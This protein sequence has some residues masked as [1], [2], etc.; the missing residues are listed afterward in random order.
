M[1][2]I[3]PSTA[4]RR[5]FRDSMR[6]T[7]ILQ[8]VDEGNEQTVEQTFDHERITIGRGVGNT[9]VLKDPTR[10]VSTKHAEI[11][12]RQGVW[13][14]CDVGS[15]NG[16]MLNG[17]RI[18]PK[19]E[20]VLHDGDQIA[21][22]QYHLSFRCAT[23]PAISQAQASPVVPVL[24]STEG[25]ATDSE[26]LGYFLHRAYGEYD[27]TS[28][29]DLDRHLDDVLHR[30][31]G[32]Y[33]GSRAQTAL[34][35]LRAVLGRSAD[36]VVDRSKPLPAQNI[37]VEHPGRPSRGDHILSVDAARKVGE[38]L[39]LSGR[40]LNPEHLAAQ[41][42]SVLQVVCVGLADAVR[43]RRTFQKEFEV[44]ATRILARTPNPIKAA[45]NAE[46]IATILLDPLSKGLSDEQAMA[47]LTDVF[48]DLT[49]HQLGLM[50][51]FRECIRGLLKE[52]DPERLE[53]GAD[54]R[55]KEKRIGLLGGGAVRAEAAAWRRYKDKHRQLSEEEVKVF[56]R[57][58]APHFSKGY[59]SVHT[60]RPRA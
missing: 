44:E 46:E 17:V 24:P 48:Q 3:E 22:G 13:S 19:Q 52:L 34:Q 35:S 59:L 18:V 32:G 55:S 23:V 39:A 42:T 27:P 58:L 53:K 29:I 36:Q 41:L 28:G 45:E 11:S 26:R 16:T 38:K 20:H 25:P 1:P 33:D 21:V 8:S 6:C 56:E 37:A 12:V 50:A 10:M 7:L 43:G 51:G 31:I 49:L 47:S 57:I 9:C 5:V 54:S 4:V 14:L 30:A 2:A 40:T 15:T 60:T